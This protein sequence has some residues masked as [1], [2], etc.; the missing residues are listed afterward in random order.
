MDNH[1]D[2][3]EGK[4][5]Y[6]SPH[7]TDFHD[8]NS[9]RTRYE[10]DYKFNMEVL[11]VHHPKGVFVIGGGYEKESV[12]DFAFIPKVATISLASGIE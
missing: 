8:D 6:G 2:D 12:M 1:W 5:N 9:F 3:S 10:F 7:S 11:F 4:Q